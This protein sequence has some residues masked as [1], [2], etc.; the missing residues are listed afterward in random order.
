MSGAMRMM[1]AVRPIDQSGGSEWLILS[2]IDA[3]VICSSRAPRAGPDERFYRIAEQLSPSM[4]STTD[5]EALNDT[6]NQTRFL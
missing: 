3:V 5:A 1:A 4:R 6:S 2:G